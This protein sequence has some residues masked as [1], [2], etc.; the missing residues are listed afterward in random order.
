MVQSKTEQYAF[1]KSRFHL[2]V[3]HGTDY[4]SET[5]GID[6]YQY[7]GTQCANHL[8]P[9]VGHVWND[10]KSENSESRAKVILVEEA[11]P[12]L[13]ENCLSIWTIVN[14]QEPKGGTNIILW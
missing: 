2:V 11:R 8:I 4:N 1:A 7:M 10:P 14:T 12:V 9:H 13:E 6:D 5:I 3:Y